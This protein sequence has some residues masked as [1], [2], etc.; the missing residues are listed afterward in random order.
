MIE[1]G[2]A[3]GAEQHRISRQTS[4]KRSW[5]QRRS[6]LL[7]CFAA[8]NVLCEMKIV[9]VNVCDLAQNTHGLLRHFRAD[10]VTGKDYDS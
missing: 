9:A 10:T 7:D 6:C 4:V 1:L 5:R 8:G 3:D 2:R